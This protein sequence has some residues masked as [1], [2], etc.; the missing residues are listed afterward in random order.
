MPEKFIDLRKW[1]KISIYL[2]IL[3]LLGVIAMV[4]VIINDATFMG[5]YD[6]QFKYQNDVE[7]LNYRDYYLFGTMRN[8]IILALLL[9]WVYYRYFKN[10]LVVQT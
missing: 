10:L 7:S 9:F 2:D 1:N 8:V 5:F 6:C 4:Y 3:I